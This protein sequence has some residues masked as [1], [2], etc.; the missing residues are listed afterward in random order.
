[1][2]KPCT[3]CGKDE[4][5][6]T[7]W[8]YKPGTKHR[9][10]KRFSKCKSCHNAERAAN[11]A[12]C[13]E[14][15]AATARRYKLKSNFGITPE[16]YDAMFSSQKGVCFICERASP[17]GR[18]LHVDHCHKTKKVRGL[19]CHDCNRG[20]GIFKDDPNLLRKAANYLNP[21]GS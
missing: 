9:E 20:L 16:Q 13:P 1:M 15:A 11:R 6:V 18:R 10:G 19:L 5:E 4:P 8:R 17:D 12:K 14:K 21:E 3:I 7:F 2:D